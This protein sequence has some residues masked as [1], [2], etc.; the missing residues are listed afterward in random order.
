MCMCHKRAECGS[1]GKHP[2]PRNGVKGASRDPQTVV[3][4]F[5][6]NRGCNWGVATGGPSG[7]WVLDV[8]QHGVA[9]GVASMREWIDATGVEFPRTFTVATGGGGWHYYFRLNASISSGAGVLPGVDVRG[10]GGY[11]LL[12]GSHHL[13]GNTYTVVDDAPVAFAPDPLVQL[14]QSARQAV[15]SGSVGGT[16]R[17]PGGVK[18][19]DHYLRHGFAVGNRDN[20]C[21]EL[22]CSLWRKHWN[23]PAFVEVA[24]ADCWRATE[25]G[26]APFPWTQAAQKIAEARKFI[27]KMRAQEASFVSQFGGAA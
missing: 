9:D 5:V 10:T 27:G 25:Q 22:A 6:D 3:K 13:S 7:V 20:E 19:L 15:P 17:G 11:V 23:D 1:P 4:W 8:D 26:D 21:Y 24:I 2:I 14:L 12:P 16:R 18:S